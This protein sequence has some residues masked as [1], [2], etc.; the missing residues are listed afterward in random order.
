MLESTIKIKSEMAPIFKITIEE[1]SSDKFERFISDKIEQSRGTLAGAIV[2][3]D[4]SSCNGESIESMV[5]FAQNCKEIL[6]KKSCHFMGVA[7]RNKTEKELFTKYNIPSYVDGKAK[8]VIKSESA[9]TT[10][11]D[12]IAKEYSES[13]TKIYRGNIRGGQSEYVEG[14][15]VI[16]FGN[17]SS[18]SELCCDGS[19]FVFGKVLGK[20]VAGARGD[21]TA[22]IYGR[23][24]KSELVSIA[25]VYTNEGYEILDNKEVLISLEPKDDK[26][27]KFKKL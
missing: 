4:L 22:V 25:G 7:S 1:L 14:K 11:E 18:G 23:E 5:A 19:V 13:L 10:K 21:K 6:E 16:V 27:L 8:G 26:K 24:F 17:V 9:S 2:S 3:V 12:R 15:N 20:V